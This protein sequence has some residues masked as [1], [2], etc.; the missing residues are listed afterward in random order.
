MWSA[1]NGHGVESRQGCLKRKTIQHLSRAADKLQCCRCL[2]T[3]IP[4]SPFTF[5]D[6]R[7]QPLIQNDAQ[8]LA[9]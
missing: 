5:D 6:F 9:P 7:A 8:A 4:A 2:G 3:R 1:A